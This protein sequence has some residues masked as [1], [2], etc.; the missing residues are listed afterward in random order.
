MKS[1]V[2]F[3]FCGLLALG[4]G[5]CS[6]SNNGNNAA[7]DNAPAVNEAVA[8]SVIVPSTTSTPTASERA[9]LISN[10]WVPGK[11]DKLHL[12]PVSKAALDAQ[13]KFGDPTAA[14]AEIV[15][16]SPKWFPPKTRVLDYHDDGKT[17]S[18]N[19]NRNF[20]DPNFWSKSGEKTTELAVYALVN[21]AAQSGK[22]VVL[23]VEKRPVQT[24]GEMDTSDSIEPNHSLEAKISSSSSSSNANT[25]AQTGSPQSDASAQTNTAPNADFSSPQTGNT[26][27]GKAGA[28]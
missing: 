5:G 2:L 26:L 3:S 24:L 14:L 4:L 21:S 20:Q 12:R 28:R 1:F 25:P 7:L 8:N 11:D 19:L 23:E 27:P 18:I 9:S 15:R 17:V 10:I 22:P 16:L 13:K 6:P